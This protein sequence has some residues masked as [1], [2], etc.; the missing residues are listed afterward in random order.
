MLIELIGCTSAGKS[1]LARKIV[2]VCHERGI[3]I[4][5]GDDHVLQLL[6]LNWIENRVVRTLLLDL[7]AYAGCL[8][9]W[10]NNFKLYAFITRTILELPRS[11]P[12]LQRLNI[13][14]NAFKKIGI[15]ELIRRTA[16]DSQIV[17]MDEGAVHTAHYLFVHVSAEPRSDDLVTF[18]ELIPLPDVAV[19]LQR[20]ETVLIERVLRRGHRRIRDATHSKVERF[21]HRAVSIFEFL[22]RQPRLREGLLIVNSRRSVVVPQEYRADAASAPL[23][24]DILEQV[25]RLQQQELEN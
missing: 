5:M 19:Y 9:G 3:C 15:S 1:T 16:G 23:F 20:D 22:A 8:T 4:S 11:L 14:R 13:A 24:L 17:M 10:L 18:L 12:V 6:R 2:Q 7:I 21:V 25:S